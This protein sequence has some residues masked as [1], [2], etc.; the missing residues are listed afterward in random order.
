MSVSAPRAATLAECTFE[1]G[2]VIGFKDGQAGVQQ[3]AFGDDNHVESISE[4]VATENLSNQ[5]FR[6][7]SLHRPAEL[8]GRRDAETPH[9]ARVGQ[10]EERAVAAVNPAP[11][12]V[13]LLKIRSASN[14][15]GWAEPWHGRSK[16]RPYSLETVRRLR[17]FARRR[18]S[19]RRPFLV[20]I[21][22]RNP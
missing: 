10:D 7:I 8:P 6:S 21:R 13:H 4:L 16:P 5:T 18:L 11:A 15:F 9:R 12:L 19:T 2:S 3:I 20:A 1:D 17:P 22:T 14:P